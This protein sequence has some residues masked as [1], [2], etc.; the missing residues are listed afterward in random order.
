MVSN[1]KLSRKHNR[2]K[3]RPPER[4]CLRGHGAKRT[5]VITALFAT[6]RM[7]SIFNELTAGY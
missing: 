5:A 6:C 3:V 2:H 4:L 1:G 7:V